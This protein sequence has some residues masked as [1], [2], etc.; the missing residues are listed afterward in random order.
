V[1]QPAWPYA[2]WHWFSTNLIALLLLVLIRTPWVARPRTAVIPG[3]VTGALITCQQH[4]GSVTTAA[5]TTLFILDHLIDRRYSHAEPI[6]QL[7]ARLLCFAAGVVLVVVP[8]L[9]TIVVAA[10]FDPVMEALVRFPLQSYRNSYHT[11]WGSLGPFGARYAAYTFPVFL[12]Y[13]SLVLLVPA[14]RIAWKLVA[15][16]DREKVRRLTVLVV[17]GIGSIGSILYYP[18]FI[19]IAFIMPILLVSMTE[20]IEWL[21]TASIRS[22]RAAGAVGWALVLVVVLGLGDHLARTHMRLWTEFPVAYDTPFG[23]LNFASHWEPVLMDR[24]RALLDQAPAAEMFCYPNLAA[25]YLTTGAKNPT[26]FQH[27]DVGVFPRRDTDRVVATLRARRVPYVLV[28]VYYLRAND[29][30][31]GFLASEYT[32]LS[33]PEVERTGEIPAFVLYARKDLAPSAEAPQLR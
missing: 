27:F 16:I 5:V 15:R 10:G 24:T 21:L 6:R 12:R 23:R 14:T 8:V 19:H 3:L 30:L 33:I 4:R 25:P 17:F 11:T 32:P 13:L 7:A 28:G 26:P 9:T 29:P 31:I 20:S 2:S 18:D 22:P 1:G